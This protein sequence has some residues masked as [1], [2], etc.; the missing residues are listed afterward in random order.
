[1]AEIDHMRPI[2]LG[3]IRLCL[4]AFV[5]T[6]SAANGEDK[7]VPSDRERVESCSIINLIVTPERYDGKR[8]ETW[9]VARMEFEGTAIYISSESAEHRA[10]VNGIYLALGGILEFPKRQGRA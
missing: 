9:G 10:R 1:M 4:L 8:I 3:G 2:N 7:A 6:C 5:L